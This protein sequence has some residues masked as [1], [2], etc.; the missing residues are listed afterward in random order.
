MDPSV[1][2]A[3]A[4][5]ARSQLSHITRL[6]ARDLGLSARSVNHRVAVGR[7]E[8]VGN[9]TLRMPGTAPTPEA[10]VMA[11]CLDVRGVA[12]HRTAA[13]LH[14]FEGFGRPLPVEVT[15]RKGSTVRSPLARVHSSTN[16]GRDDVVLTGGI[17][18]T[19]V[20]R[21]LLDLAALVP[22]DVA[23]TDLI[24][25]LEAAV[26]DKR[27]S[28]RWLWWR[29]E[30][31]RCRGRN[32]V[33]VFESVLAERASLGPTESWLERETLRII[34]EAGLPKPTL[35]RVI[36]RSGAFAARVDFLYEGPAVVLEV[37]GKWHATP[38]RIA[39]DEARVNALQLEGYCVLQFGYRAIIE[40]P[41]ETTSTIA[42]LLFSNP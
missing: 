40:T 29:L 4:E 33:S 35:Q 10:A 8:A 25:A 34:A 1:E 5:R 42:Q 39:A 30:E 27:A 16:L 12:S 13:W 32:G 23:R 14:R 28:D 3:I 17:P 20:A 6:Q 21:T 7:F 31:L 2:R 41:R 18:T 38:G 22:N 19:G 24:G 26:R 36:R 15:V 11:A 9:G 37:K